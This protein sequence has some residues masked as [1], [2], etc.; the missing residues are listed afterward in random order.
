M[1]ADPGDLNK[2]AAVAIELDMVFRAGRHVEVAVDD[3][4]A[5]RIA[6]RYLAAIDVNIAEDAVARQCAAGVDIDH[7]RAFQR[8]VDVEIAGIDVRRPGIF[9]DAG[10]H[11][12][13]GAFLVKLPVPLMTPIR[14]FPKGGLII[15]DERS[16]VHEGAR[17]PGAMVTQ[18]SVPAEIVVPLC[19]CRP[20]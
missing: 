6:R 18:R 1:F 19:A 20:G 16:V 14:A 12:L 13:A 15:H 11:Q 2:V 9:L 7:R 5:N 3:D 17:M 10:H 8:A 4:G